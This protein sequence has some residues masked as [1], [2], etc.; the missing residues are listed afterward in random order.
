MCLGSGNLFD[1]ETLSRRRRL[2][3]CRSERRLACTDRKVSALV[4]L[5]ASDALVSAEVDGCPS[6]ASSDVILQEGEDELELL[7]DCSLTSSSDV[8]CRK[9]AMSSNYCFGWLNFSGCCGAGLSWTNSPNL[10]D[11]HSRG[12]WHGHC[13]WTPLHTSWV[14][15]ASNVAL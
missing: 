15:F 12:Q 1:L 4:P 9:R 3:N 7:E 10:D 14:P 13:R 2:C 5:L 8:M 6:T 11:T